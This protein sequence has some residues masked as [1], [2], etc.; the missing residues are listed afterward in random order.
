MT[1]LFAHPYNTS[2]NG[3]YFSTYEEYQTKSSKL[4]DSF[5]LPVEEFELEYIDGDLPQLFS[6]CSIDQCTLELWFDEIEIMDDQNQVELFYRCENLNQEPQEAIDK[7]NNDGTI[8][9]GSVADYAYDFIN[10]YGTIDCLPENIQRYFDHEA[11]AHDLELS[12]EVTE[13][14]YDSITYTAS[15]FQLFKS[16]WLCSIRVLLQQCAN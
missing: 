5:G 11:F 3:F 15:G 2:A 6:A 7:L 9:N 1:E 14:S 13:F 12:G 16:I 10:D 4:T 8:Y